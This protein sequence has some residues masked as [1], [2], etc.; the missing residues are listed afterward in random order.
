M[1]FFLSFQ[2]LRFFCN[3]CLLAIVQICRKYRYP[4]AAG[5]GIREFTSTPPG[6]PQL[7]S[8]SAPPTQ[9]RHSRVPLPY[10]GS[11]VFAAGP[12]LESVHHRSFSLLMIPSTFRH[13][14]NHHASFGFWHLAANT[15]RSS[16]IPPPDLHAGLDRG[17]WCLAVVTRCRLP[18]MS[19]MYTPLEL[20][21]LWLAPWLTEHTD[22]PQRNL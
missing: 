4:G 18:P 20:G 11:A 16:L 19:P 17:H 6:I 1:C 7:S 9:P 13:H 3:L 2:A 14:I 10:P 22:G 5:V 8:D 21:R 15:D 12:G